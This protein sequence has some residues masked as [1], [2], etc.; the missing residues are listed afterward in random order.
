MA[1]PGMRSEP[2]AAEAAPVRWLLVCGLHR[3]GTS[4]LL[5]A[6]RRARR[7]PVADEPLNERRGVRGVPVAYPYVP[8]AGGAYARLIDE[9]ADRARPWGR[10]N[11]LRSPESA[12]RA[13]LYRL[14]GGRS[15]LSWRAQ[16]A[17][18]ALGRPPR[19]AFW[20]DPFATLATPYLVRRHPLRAV[21][22]VRHPAAVYLSTV[23]QGW[24][25]EAD[26]LSRQGELLRDYGYGILPADWDL[27]RRNPAAAVALLWKFMARINSDVAAGPDPLLLLRHEDLCVSP[28]AALESAATH[29]GLSLT[30]AAR[31]FVRS[32]SEGARATGV[33]GRPHDFDRDSRALV[34]AWRGSISAADER[35][36][37]DMVGEDL[38]RIYSKW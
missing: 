5:A 12:L 11:R 25:F 6:L 15:G 26:N 1:P 36:I 14:S 18:S 19:L 30:D 28:E 21:C 16:R 31:G 27:A 8:V 29:L 7:L 3:S 34:N 9:V 38:L 13:A 4:Y 24:V 20:K 33:A 22:L 17:A 23:R 2:A 10:G 32:K 37:R 35:V